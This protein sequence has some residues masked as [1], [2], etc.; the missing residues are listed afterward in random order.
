MSWLGFFEAV[1]GVG[2]PVATVAGWGLALATAGWLAW[3][4]VRPG[5]MDERMAWASVCVLTI[6]P[7]CRKRWLLPST[8][9]GKK[10]FCSSA[11]TTS[12][13]PRVRVMQA[14]L[15][16]VNSLRRV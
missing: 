1:L 15:I 5:D 4:F 13:T 14:R 16:A 11:V 6:E 2:D 9:R 12:S 10:A 8:P 3:K 7:V